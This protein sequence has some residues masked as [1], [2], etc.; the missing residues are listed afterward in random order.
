MTVSSRISAYNRRR[1]WNIFLELV[2][3]LDDMR[4][5]DVGFTED[6]YSETDNYI[7]KHYEYPHNITAL[8]IDTPRAFLE[9]YPEVTTVQYDGNRFPF[10]DKEFDIC[11][12]NAVIEHVG[13]QEKQIL[14]LREIKRVSKCAFI[15]TPNRYF[16]IEVHTKTPLIHW[17]PKRIFDNYLSATNKKWATGNYMNLLSYKG[18]SELCRKAGIRQYSII[19]N[20]LLL[21]T[22]DFII[23]FPED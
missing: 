11:W 7:E 21:L 20:R 3:P 23:Y 18:I 9:R 14:F 6:E 12:S 2:N 19:R 1:K 16:P 17:L 22:L 10:D 15:T 5:L 8:G 13:N 4:V